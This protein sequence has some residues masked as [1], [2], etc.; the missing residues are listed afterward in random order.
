MKSSKQNIKLTQDLTPMGD[1]RGGYRKLKI[2]IVTI[3]IAHVA[4]A[5]WPLPEIPPVKYVDRKTGGLKTE[6]IEGVG[7]LKWLYYNPVGE[8]S[9]HALVKRKFI[10]DW[11]GALMDKPSS[12][13]NV[14]PFV[15]KYGIDMSIVEKHQFD[16]FNDFFTR[17]L[18]QDAR[19]VNSDSLVVVSPADGKIFV[20]ENIGKKDFYVKG[21]RFNIY[22]F[23]QDS[24]LA[25]DYADGVMAII[26]LAPPDYHRYHFPVDGKIVKKKKIDG[27]YYSVSPLALRKLA[28]IFCMNKR[29][30]TVI[31]TKEF[32]DVVM[33][34]VGATMVGSIIDTYKSDLVTKGEEK[35]YFKFGG[36][37][38]VLLF[39]KGEVIVD[40]DLKKNSNR[41]LE[42]S[43]E[44]GERIAASQK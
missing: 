39:E 13:E 43:V 20:F 4:I 40:D 5:F 18:K 10:S 44:M 30:Y 21:Y 34:E 12:A 35:G 24:L 29:E 32:G 26:R 11:Y 33:C 23:L 25:S 6:K 16:S 1:K 36:S 37:T 8:M 27:D 14:G 3:V 15:E 9:L 31:D 19:P 2:L 17:K 41:N 22:E 7:W 42:T 28:E 38:V